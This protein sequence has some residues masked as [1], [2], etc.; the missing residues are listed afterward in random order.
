[1]MNLRVQIERLKRVG[2]I[3]SLLILFGVSVQ[4]QERAV[5]GKV[6]SKSDGFEI[7][8]ATVAVKGTTR[9]T[10]TDMDGAYTVKVSGDEDILIFSFIGLK[11]IEV[12]VGD[13]SVIDISLEEDAILVDE[14]VVTALGIKRE[15]KSLGY[16]TSEVNAEAYENAKDANVMSSLSGRMA[17]VQINS[18]G[19]GA[20][21]SSSVVIRGAANLSAS[22][23]PLY[24]ID[25][26]PMSNT[27][28]SN[29]DDSNNGGVDSGN[30]MSAVAA[31]DISNI[32]ILKGPAATALY[33]T[34]AIN[35]VVLITTKSG[36]GALGTS[37]TYNSNY[38]L[39]VA[40]IYSDWQQEYG[41]GTYGNAPTTAT[42]ADENTSS[43]GSSYSDVSE[44]INYRGDAA[45]YIYN[46]NE[47]EFFELG[48]TW[49]NSVA[50][51]HN[52]EDANVRLS[53][54]NTSNDG[55][56]PETEYNRNTINLSGS[57]FALDGKL[58]VKAKLSYTQE[59]S[60]NTT[61][62]SS[63]FNP[64][65][66]LLS[67]PNNISLDE[68]KDYKDEETGTPIGLGTL[69]SNPYWTIN[70]IDRTYSKDRIMAMISAKYNFT[71]ELS[72]QIRFGSDLT[73][74]SDETIYPIG[75]PYYEPGKAN[76]SKKDDRET[77]FDLLATYDKD[78]NEKFG[79]T[80]NMGSSR[81]DKE[82]ESVGVYS[83]GF[84]DPNLQR[85]GFG[86]TNTQSVGYTNKRINSVYG[87]AQFRYNNM[88]YVDVS[89]RNDWSSALALDNNSF[90][91][92]SVSTS[93]IISEAVDMPSWFTFA[94][95][96]GS[97]ARVGSDTDPYQLS[98]Q[99]GYDSETHEGWNGETI[100]VGGV[101]GNQIS[102]ANLKPS[103]M[104]SY[105]AGLDMK[106]FNNRLGVDVTYY[107]SIARDQIMPVTVSSASGYST[108]IVNSGEIQNKGWELSVYGSPIKTSKFEWNSTFNFSNNQNEVLEL[109]NGVETLVLM[110]GG[111]VSVVAAP[112]ME[113]GT[114]WGSVYERD[115]N[116]A[117]ALDSN[118]E[119]TATS[120]YESLGGGYHSTMMGWIN[121]FTY[122]NISLNLV[123]DSK[124]GGEVFSSTES[125]AYSSGKHK[126]TLERSEY[127]AGQEWSPSELEGLTTTAVPELYYSA[128]SSVDEQFVYDASYIAIQELSVAYR[129]PA[130]LFNKNS[131][132][133]S[134]NLGAFSRNLGYI[135]RGTDNIDPQ[136][137]YS[138]SNGGGGIE[139]GAMSLP[140]TYGFNLGVKF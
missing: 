3:L 22:N 109:A 95:A 45:A 93:F 5:T 125:Q 16:A 110:S 100:P 8:G 136:S 39:E 64:S 9:G 135:Y 139:Q 107:N 73:F 68:L 69:E 6:T 132:I 140:A 20:G 124:F 59:T 33:G 2:V 15:K 37:V 57:T 94:K 79:L 88:L 129:L 7:A 27:Q 106:F 34:R 56:V 61:M 97:W 120:T 55:L 134:V 30:G 75:T 54:S 114:I 47:K 41:Q 111:G 115:E 50:V 82:F 67:V 23:E 130:H 80:V 116:G 137:A 81:T 46:D 96:R 89:A 32:S 70:E 12:P 78:F 35:G 108:A 17:G 63:P 58:D 112:G 117:I 138:I 44:I 53:Y 85:P 25:G 105:E 86:E 119:P 71:E 21:A 4:A 18:T 77:N 87:T 131:F 126:N 38:T 90:F 101:S 29:A 65:S 128:V 28:F 133:K 52:G 26:V 127:S 1:M 24:V 19:Q 14:V 48:G 99:Y 118:G 72:A 36:K 11:S 98:Q 42:E 122:Q 62:G 103:I 13:K 74:F 121:S 104:T 51:S 66:Q 123:I 91:Y 10:I 31:D 83:D 43:W 84:S 76:M 92:P 49:T 102:N 60:S 113:Y 40:K